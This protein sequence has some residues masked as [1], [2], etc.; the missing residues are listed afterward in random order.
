MSYCPKCGNKVDE[1]MTFCPQMRRF[2]EGGNC[3][4]RGSNR[5]RLQYYQT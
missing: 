5:E 2:I 3:L 4:A 1:T